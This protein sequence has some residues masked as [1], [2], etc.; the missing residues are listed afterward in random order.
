MNTKSSPAKVVPVKGPG[1]KRF[2]LTKSQR[3]GNDTL[4][5]KW[6]IK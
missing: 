4:L 6:K 5:N 1:L 3:Y 2:P